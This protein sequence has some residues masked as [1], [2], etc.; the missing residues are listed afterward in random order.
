MITTPLTGRELECLE[1]VSHG[2]TSWEI[3]TILDLSER[4]VNFHL[5]NACQKLG[6]YGRQHAV[7]KALK[8]GMLPYSMSV[9]SMSVIA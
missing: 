5:R 4:T 1:W 7:A 3:G 6:V 8:S 9:T 2:K